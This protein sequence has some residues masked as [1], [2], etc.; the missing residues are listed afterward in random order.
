MEND[1]NPIQS[2]V[3]G[4]HKLLALINEISR[5]QL[6]IEEQAEMA[7][8][9]VSV[10]YGLPKLP[11]DAQEMGGSTR[12]EV[13]SVYQELGLVKFLEPD[14]DIRGLVL[15]ALYN[16]LNKITVGLDEVYKKA[17][18]RNDRGICFTGEN[19]KVTIAFLGENV[20]WFDSGCTLYLRHNVG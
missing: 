15:V 19:S 16:V 13:I 1:V 10:L 6:P 3:E 9:K 5:T 20:S 14:D 11:E 17:G 4:D 18:K 12:E 2:W 7:F 8:H